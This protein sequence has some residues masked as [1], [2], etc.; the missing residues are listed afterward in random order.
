[1]ALPR[2]GAHPN[3]TTRIFVARIP[4][5]VQDAQFR[6]YFEQF[7]RVQDAYMP[8]DAFKQAHR[9]IGFVTYAT[10]E[11]VEQVGLP[12]GHACG[13]R[14]C[15]VRNIECLCAGAFGCWLCHQANTEPAKT[16]ELPVWV[17][18]WRSIPGCRDA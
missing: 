3:R 10:A 9:G 13:V 8:K 2:G 17:L 16:H 4:P 11:P 14:L 18:G 1:M 5:T 7:G 15:S 6:T 12:V